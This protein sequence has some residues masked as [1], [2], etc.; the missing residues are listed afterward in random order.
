MSVT[1]DKGNDIQ[2]NFT[3]Q[4]EDGNNVNIASFDDYMVTLYDG[5]GSVIREYKDSPTGDQRTIYSVDTQ[6]MRIYIETDD[7]DIYSPIRVNFTATVSNT[8]LSDNLWNI[9]KD[10]ETIYFR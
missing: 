7:S 3:I 9:D 5:T 6:Q 1:K 8:D 10:I 2:V 4:D